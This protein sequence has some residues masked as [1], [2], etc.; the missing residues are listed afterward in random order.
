MNCVYQF[1]CR[2]SSFLFFIIVHHRLILFFLLL[3]NYFFCFI[4]TFNSAYP[5]L[6]TSTFFHRCLGRRLLQMKL[7][8]LN[9][10]DLFFASADA[11]YFWLTPKKILYYSLKKM[12][13]LLIWRKLIIIFRYIFWYPKKRDKRFVWLPTSTQP[14]K[15][16]IPKPEKGIFYFSLFLLSFSNECVQRTFVLLFFISNNQINC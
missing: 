13:K 2:R 1:R 14:K 15:C 10:D 4:V 8:L 7:W 11:C 9:D 3:P 5:Y 6:F 12:I 16:V